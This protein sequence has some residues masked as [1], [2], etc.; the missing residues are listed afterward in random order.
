[1]LFIAASPENNEI[2]LSF[3]NQEYNCNVLCFTSAISENIFP[4]F[5][6]YLFTSGKLT[7][8]QRFSK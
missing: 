7:R 5:M 8:R 3:K 1:M 2:E 4:V 6:E